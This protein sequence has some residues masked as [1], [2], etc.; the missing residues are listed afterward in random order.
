MSQCGRFTSKLES[1][2]SAF[3]TNPDGSTK[4]LF[5]VVSNLSGFVIVD[6]EKRR[7]GR[8]EL[9]GVS[10]KKTRAP[11]R[12]IVVSPDQQTLCPQRR[13]QSSLRL[14]AA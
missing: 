10:I 9:P 13:E 3:E 11:A 12:G 8:I 1:A 14:P 6:F 5:A 4:R 7:L 2:Q